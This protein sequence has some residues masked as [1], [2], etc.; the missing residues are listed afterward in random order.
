MSAAVSRA[1][2]C[3]ERIVTLEEYLAETRSP[4][5]HADRGRWLKFFASG[6]AMVHFR[7]GCPHRPGRRK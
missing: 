5:S 1:V 4:L 6:R 3:H 7:P 2:P